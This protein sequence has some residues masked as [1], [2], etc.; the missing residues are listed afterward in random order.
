MTELEG[1]F[2]LPLEGLGCDPVKWWV[3]NQSKFPTLS[4]FARDILSI[5]GESLSSF[6]PCFQFL[7]AKWVSQGS[8]VAVE[9]VFSGGRDTI[10]LRRASLSAETIRA[11]MLV[12]HQLLLARERHKKSM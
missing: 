9:R 11:L 10:S 6:L 2:S 3:N 5:P 8:A 12:K 4:K 1:Y 7:I